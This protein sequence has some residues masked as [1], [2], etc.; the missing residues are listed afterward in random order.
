MAAEWRWDDMHCPP[1]RATGSRLHRPR[2]ELCIKGLEHWMD[3]MWADPE[4]QRRR[5]AA[6]VS[7]P[8]MK[9]TGGFDSLARKHQLKHG[10]YKNLSLALRRKQPPQ[11]L[12]FFFPSSSRHT[13]I[14]LPQDQG[15]AEIGLNLFCTWE[16]N[17][18]LVLHQLSVS[19]GYFCQAVREIRLLGLLTGPLSYVLLYLS[20]SIRGSRWNHLA[21]LRLKI[22]S[23]SIS[24]FQ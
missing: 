6:H 8:P 17:Q 16:N 1:P 22:I 12:L 24:I 2:G 11:E 19:D 14:A 13:C 5:A 23:I 4:N 10:D 3:Q 20:C 9:S 15:E 21:F 7:T 18:A